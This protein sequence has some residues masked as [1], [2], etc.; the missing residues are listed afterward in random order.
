MT[1]K[2]R[3]GRVR[4]FRFTTGMT[5]GTAAAEQD[6]LLSDCF[7]PTSYYEIVRDID[8]I[9]SGLIGRSG[10]GKTAILERLKA[11]RFRTVSV[12]PEELAFRYLGESDLI[13]SLR[14]S[15]VNLDYLYKL[16][17]RHVF[18]VEILKHRFPDEAR[19]AGLIW[20]L[21][22]RIQKNVR[23]DSA[24][25]RAIR[26]L[27]EWGT[28][29]MQEPHERIQQIHNN[30]EQHLRASLK[31][32]GPWRAIFGLE[33]SVDGEVVRK[34]EVEQRVRKAQEVVSQIQVQDL[35]AVKEYIGTEIID[36]PQNPCFV[37]I[38]DLDKFWAEEPILYELIRAMLLEIYDWSSV[39]NVKIIYALRDNVLHKLESNFRSR[40]YQREK[41]ADQQIRLQWTHQELIDLADKRLAWLA[42]RPGDPQAPHLAS[43]LPRKT[44]KR[45]SGLDYILERTMNRPRDVID[46]LNR[47]SQEAAGKSR[48]TWNDLRESEQVY[49]RYRLGALND[50]WYENYAGL[51]LVAEK[52]LMGMPARFHSSEWGEEILFDLFTD[53]GVDDERPWL[54]L[55]SE[56]FT[57]MYQKSNERALNYFTTLLASVMF[58]VGLVGIKDPL[59]QRESYSTPQMPLWSPRA[60]SQDSEIFIRPM[61]HT[62]LR[63]ITGQR[64]R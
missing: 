63:V 19:Q 50:E 48:F 20:Q 45:P 54:K 43:L 36:D 49:S 44:N 24:R 32:A 6:S 25:V 28:T 23:P 47:A 46:F 16:L 15:G 3:P 27:D 5:F 58:E 12:N 38:D 22:E 39:P 60:I 37:L 56:K 33:A 42:G 52:L 11:D 17:W 21:I 57:R 9:R 8:D 31:V 18:V 34:E 7:F 62:A 64:Y 35:N 2:N 59:D 51:D 14:E 29:V 41:L 13:R 1:T 55:Q 10:S 61:F 30:F 53:A 26:Y 40:T 4:E